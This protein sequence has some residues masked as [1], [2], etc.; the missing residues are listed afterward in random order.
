MSR[1]MLAATLLLLTAAAGADER[2]PTGPLP[3]I[4][5]PLLLQRDG[6]VAGSRRPAERKGF[7]AVSLAFVGSDAREWIGVNEART[8]GGD[9]PLDG[10]AALE[11]VE[12]FTP[13]FLV[14][15]SDD[16][17]AR[18]Q[19]ATLGTHVRIEGLVERGSRAYQL[20]RVETEP[21]PRAG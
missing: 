18:L 21:R 16:V 12:P 17:I 5:P 9:Q 19:D 14:A 1:V 8:A 4:A 7:T 13:N 6:V 10:K 2:V 11:Q 3:N 20:R 15:G